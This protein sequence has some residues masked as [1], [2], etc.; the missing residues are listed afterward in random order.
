[1]KDAFALPLS[2]RRPICCQ[3]RVRYSI[4]DDDDDVIE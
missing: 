2:Q 3:T 1:M 4:D